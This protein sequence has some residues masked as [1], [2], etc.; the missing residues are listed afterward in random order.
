MEQHPQDHHAGEVPANTACSPLHP[1]APFT[2]VANGF[3][4]TYPS[5]PIYWK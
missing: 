2:Q 4:I 3:I 1:W 5:M